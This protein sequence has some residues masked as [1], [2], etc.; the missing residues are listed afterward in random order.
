MNFQLP[1]IAVLVIGNEA[2]SQITHLQRLTDCCKKS[3]IDKQKRGQGQHA[4]ELMEVHAI[5]FL[6]M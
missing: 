1:E 2:G 4:G 6:V 3:D 5:T